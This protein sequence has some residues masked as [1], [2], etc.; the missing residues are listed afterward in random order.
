M[1]KILVTPNT[2]NPNPAELAEPATEGPNVDTKRLGEDPQCPNMAE[3]MG[4]MMGGL[5]LYEEG[6]QVGELE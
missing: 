5:L 1:E 4:K 2:T 3:S 6:S